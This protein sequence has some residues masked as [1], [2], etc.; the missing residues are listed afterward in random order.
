MAPPPP[1][2]G[3]GMEDWVDSD[4]ESPLPG[5]DN[6]WS[7]QLDDG[8]QLCKPDVP[9]VALDPMQSK[10][11]VLVSSREVANSQV[12]FMNVSE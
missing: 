2:L 8:K 10:G 1:S 6:K 9:F 3:I 5:C 12:R 4:G 11:M 7:N